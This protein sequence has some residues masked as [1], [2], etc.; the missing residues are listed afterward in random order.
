MGDRCIY[1][2]ISYYIKYKS[3]QVRID[4]FSDKVR[5]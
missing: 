3:R 1:M 4:K 5:L 2:S